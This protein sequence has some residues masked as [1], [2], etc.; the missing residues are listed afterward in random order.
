MSCDSHNYFDLREDITCG[1]IVN[2]KV[3]K[4]KQSDIELNL[5]R[6]LKEKTVNLKSNDYSV[7]KEMLIDWLC[8]F[9]TIMDAPSRNV[10]QI[11]ILKF[12]FWSKETMLSKLLD[13]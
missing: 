11:N 4:N 2:I 12:W 6:Y 13:K 9:A 3:V 10:F 5:L 7:L 8:F 1:P